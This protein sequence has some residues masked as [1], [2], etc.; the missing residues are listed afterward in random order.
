[1]HA[2]LRN[3]SIRTTSPRPTLKAHPTL[4]WGSPPCLNV[5]RNPALKTHPMPAWGRPPGLNV[6]RNLALKA[7]PIPTWGVA[8]GTG[9]TTAKGLK[10]RSMP[11][12]IP[13]IPLIEINAIP[14]QE[15][16]KL[17]LKTLLRMMRL[18]PVDV[19]AQRAQIR[20]TNG[21]HT[22]PALPLE[23]TELVALRLQ[24]LRRPRLQIADEVCDGQA[25][26]QPNCQ[27]EMIGHAA[28]PITFASG[29]T[30]SRCKV[31]AQV[32]THGISQR[33]HP[34]FGAEDYMNQNKSERLWHCRNYRSGLQPSTYARTIPGV[35]PQA[36]IER[37][38]SAQSPTSNIITAESQTFRTQPTPL[39]GIPLEPHTPS[40]PALKAR[41]IPAWV[42]AQLITQPTV[43]ALKARPIPAWDEAP[44]A[45][46]GHNRG[47]KAQ[48]MPFAMVAD[49][50]ALHQMDRRT[51]RDPLLEL[52]E[53]R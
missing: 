7:R 12:S 21:K 22:V 26:R 42:E 31:G 50:A 25:P 32:R 13:N 44:G 28:D 36:G 52:P 43:P 8:P 1:M 33:R 16:T 34:A 14:L 3:T 29:V 19:R 38:F 37:A 46:T 53:H 17:V 6:P 2:P 24:P 15:R 41:P 45:F 5:P 20:G 18:L 51:N 11:L 30:N 23:A 4:A 48:P 27:M 39:H 10:A 35:S 40:I 49:R 47:L 9:R